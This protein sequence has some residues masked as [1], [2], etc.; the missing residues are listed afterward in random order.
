M[1]PAERE[2]CE[3]YLDRLDFVDRREEGFD[4]FQ[5]GT[6]TEILGKLKDTS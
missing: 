6:K 2:V 5:S 1:R 4:Y 3:G